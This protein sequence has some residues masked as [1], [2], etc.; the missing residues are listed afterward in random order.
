MTRRSGFTLVEMVV[1]VMIL[2]IIAAIAVPKVVSV[3]GSAQDQ[4]IEHSIAVVGDAVN[5]YATV[6]AG[7]LPGADGNE[8]SF[9]NDL[10]PYLHKF[11]VN[12]K[13]NSDSVQ[14]VSAGV[15]PLAPVVGKYGWVYDNQSGDFIANA[16]LPAGTGTASAAGP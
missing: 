5:H 10:K 8:D 9:K 13:R 11:P 4:T 15:V 2:G 16:D 7:K 6:N 12:P 14:V 1:T 3:I